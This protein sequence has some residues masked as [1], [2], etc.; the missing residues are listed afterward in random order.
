MLHIRYCVRRLVHV[1][2]REGGRDN[3]NALYKLSDEV[4]C[5]VQGESY[6]CSAE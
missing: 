1:P 6:T 2:L 4:M 3:V 5:I